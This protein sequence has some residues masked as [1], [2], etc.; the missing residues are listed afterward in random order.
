MLLGRRLH[1]VVIEPPPPDVQAR[2]RRE[3]WFTALVLAAAA[4]GWLFR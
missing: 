3:G 1:P 2:I 4:L